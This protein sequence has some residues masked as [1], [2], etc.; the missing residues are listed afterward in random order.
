MKLVLPCVWLFYAERFARIQYLLK[1][2][3]EEGYN[4]E[5]WMDFPQ[6]E[7]TDVISLL[8]VTNIPSAPAALTINLEGYEVAIP[9]ATRLRYPI[10]AQPV[11]NVSTSSQSTY[12][13]P[14]SI[15]SRMVITDL[16]RI[17]TLFG[18]PKRISTEGSKP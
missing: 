17:R 10:E 15:K 5:N 12:L 3:E 9:E 13:L 18:I 1:E 14:S 6:E 11:A 16:E 4:M 7:G 8:R 2:M